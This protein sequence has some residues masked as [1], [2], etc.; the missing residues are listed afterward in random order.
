V[1]LAVL[2]TIVLSTAATS[3]E[4][5][6]PPQWPS[7]QNGGRRFL[8]AGE[9]PIRWTPDENIV[10]QATIEGYGQSTPVVDGDQVIVTSTSGAKKNKYHLT[11]FEL[12]SGEKLWQQDFDNP[13]PFE[14]TPMVSRAAPTPVATQSGYTVFFEGGVLIGVSKQGEVHWQRNLVADYGPIT[15]RHGLASSLE[16]DERFVFVWVER[17]EL[18]YLVAIDPVDGKTIWK[19]DGLGATSWSSPRLVPTADGPH[20]VCSASG[21]IV[22]FDPATGARLWE[23]T[24]IANN[25]SC[26]P[27]PIGDGKFL[28]GASDGRGETSGSPAA[29]S[30]GVIKISKRPDGTY[31][32]AFVWQAEKATSTFGS[33]VIAG[34]MALIVNRTGVLYRLNLQTG[35]SLSAERTEAGGIWATPLV[36]GDHLYLF[37]YKGTT[38]VVS[39]SDGKELATNR[40]WVDTKAKTAETGALGSGASTAGAAFGGGHVLYAAAAAPPFLLLRRGDTLFAVKAP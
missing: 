24:E 26:T 29:A 35:E 17:S 33:P 4:P 31:S 39:L 15:A 16:Q 7:F 8:P 27:S 20:L 40:L 13:S 34:D 11:A 23:F 2:T 32:A 1:L 25:T 37:G 5:L 36:A 18:P 14:N 30:N 22:G 12:T 21:K 38:S 3:S 9:L 19:V 10:W 6:V 28:I